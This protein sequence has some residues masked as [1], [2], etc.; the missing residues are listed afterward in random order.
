MIHISSCWG[1]LPN[2]ET[3]QKPD[4]TNTT[5]Q[6]KF[7]GFHFDH[8]LLQ[9]LINDILPPFFPLPSKS[10]STPSIK[11]KTFCI[12]MHPLYEAS[13]CS[14]TACSDPLPKANSPILTV[15]SIHKN[16]AARTDLISVFQEIAKFHTKS[17]SLGVKHRP[18]LRN[19]ANFE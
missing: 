2:N 12:W 1:W 3:K 7:F 4:S 19:N 13:D 11:A 5:Y 17:T 9:S 16:N 18:K 15:S 10:L 6:D 14:S 8:T